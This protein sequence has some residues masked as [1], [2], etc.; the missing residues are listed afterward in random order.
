M[1]LPGRGDIDDFFLITAALSD[2]YK[3]LVS[4]PI[5]GVA[6]YGGAMGPA[7]LFIN[8]GGYKNN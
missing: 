7:Q 4:C 3:T 5:A 2:P 8:L 1:G 6:G